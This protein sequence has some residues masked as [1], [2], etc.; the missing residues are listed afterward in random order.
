MQAITEFWAWW[1]SYAATAAEMLRSQRADELEA[2]LTP[3]V[4]EIDAELIWETGKPSTAEFCLVVSAGGVA[5]QRATAERWLRAAPPADETWEFAA[6]RPASPEALD[7]KLVVGDHDFD[8]SHVSYRAQ[9]NAQ[10]AR[11]DL[12]IYHPDFAFVDEELRAQVGFLSLDWAIGEDNVARWI[13]AVAL[14]EVE[15]IDTIPAKSL[16]AVIDQ[17]AG[18][19]GNDNWAMLTG[20]TEDG[21]DLMATARFPLRRVNFPLYDEHVGIDLEFK[22]Q[23]PQGFPKSKS[24]DALRGFEES[25]LSLL[26][27]DGALV[28]HETSSGVRTF[29]VYVDSESATDV[30]KRIRALAASWKEGDATVRTFLDPSWAAVT[31]MMT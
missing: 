26:E 3:R 22:R 10:R 29:H 8:L 17:I 16:L 27:G 1:Q 25:L 6:S 20:K 15:P 19:Y 24:L 2:E 28:V 7:S 14:A 12:S 11:F 13:G 9:F 31:P 4:Q 18:N 5:A 23:T 30:V 21:S